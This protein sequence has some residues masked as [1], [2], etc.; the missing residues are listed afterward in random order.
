MSGSAGRQGIGDVV[1]T[2]QIELDMRTAK[3]AAQGE[4]LAAARI[5]GQI[6]AMEIGAGV[7]QGEAEHLA[8]GGAALPGEEGLVIQIEHGHAIVRQTFENLALGFDDFLRAAELTDMG[9]AGIGDD[10]HLRPGQADGVGDLADMIGAQL[11]HP[12]AMFRR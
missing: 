4:A 5:T 7:A 9:I 12:G 3:R 1:L 6:A 2:E 8:S 11:D 10:R